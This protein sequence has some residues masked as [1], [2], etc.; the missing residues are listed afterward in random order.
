[1]LNNSSRGGSVHGLGFPRSLWLPCPYLGGK[2]ILCGLL[3]FCLRGI[4]IPL[5]N[6]KLNKLQAGWKVDGGLGTSEIQMNCGQPQGLNFAAPTG[7]P[8]P[9]PFLLKF[10]WKFGIPG[11]NNNCSTAFMG[12]GLPRSTGR[13]LKGRAG[14][15]RDELEELISSQAVQT[16]HS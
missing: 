15:V 9:P 11:Y 4:T 1:M 6:W 16:L 2:P 12:K 14:N 8:F 5:L 13:G 7:A 10:S 3:C